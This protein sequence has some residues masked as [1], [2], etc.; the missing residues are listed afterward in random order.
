MVNTAFRVQGKTIFLT[1]ARCDYPLPDFMSSLRNWTLGAATPIYV[2]VSHELH[3]DGTPHRHALV[4]YNRRFDLRDATKFDITNAVGVR[5]HPRIERPRDA[6]ATIVYIKKDGTFEEWTDPSTTQDDDDLYGRANTMNHNEFFEWTRRKRIP[7]QYA[8]LAWSTVRDEVSQITFDE[9]PNADLHLAL[10]EGLSNFNFSNNLTNVIVGPTGCGKTLTS[11][12]KMTKPIL[13]VSHVDQLKLFQPSRH[14][15]ILFDDMKFDHLP[16]TS[17]I[18]LCDRILPRSIHRRYG[19]T[20]IPVGIQVTI[21]CN[22]RPF[23]YH[24]AVAR[25]CNTLIIE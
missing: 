15:S 5:Y 1:Y 22:E 7:Y 4:R 21:T 25:R 10:P 14:R 6:E 19:I 20:L 16:V 12:R 8:A 13:F 3:Q 2:V 17:Q 23:V 9:D 18:H 24:P 11:L